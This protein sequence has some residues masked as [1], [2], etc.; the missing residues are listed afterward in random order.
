[1]EPQQL[2]VTIAEAVDD[3]FYPTS[4]LVSAFPKLTHRD[5]VRLEKQAV[6]QGLLFERRGPDGRTYLA[7]TSEG[8]RA[9]RANPLP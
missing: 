2:L 9:L 5:L 6:R 1:V 4:S 8:W 3:G 7:L